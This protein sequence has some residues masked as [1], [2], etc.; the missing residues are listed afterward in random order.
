MTL[1]EVPHCSLIS[2]RLEVI[3]KNCDNDMIELF[4]SR[5]AKYIRQNTVQD[6]QGKTQKKE[7]NTEDE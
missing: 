4:V 3:D 1:D 2:Q 7:D 5:N 6:V